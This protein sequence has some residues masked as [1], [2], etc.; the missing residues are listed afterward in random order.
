MAIRMQRV[1]C[2]AC[3]H[4]HTFSIPV[5]AAMSGVYGYTCPETGQSAAIGPQGQWESSEY[6]AQ[7]AVELSPLGVTPEAPTP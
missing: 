1:V 7:G 3:G 5:G 6:P 2:P 4:G